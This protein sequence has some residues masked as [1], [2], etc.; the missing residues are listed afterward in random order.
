MHAV[1]TMTNMIRNTGFFIFYLFFNKKLEKNTDSVIS[2]NVL[3]L[4]AYGSSVLKNI[5]F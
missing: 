4:K 3:I 2:K 1:K 5:A